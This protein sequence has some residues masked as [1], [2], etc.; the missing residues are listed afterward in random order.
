MLTI[1]PGAI[2][3]VNIIVPKSFGDQRG[4]FCEVYNRKRFFEHGIT[5]E[6][7]QD[8][9][10]WSALK[11]TVRGLH[12]Q[13]APMAQ[14]KLVW[15]PHGRIFDV[16][17]DLRRSSPSYGRWVTEEL[18]AENGRQLLI[19]VGFAHGFCTLEPD[20]HVFYK[21]T[22]Y[23]SPEADFGIAWDD[24]DLA[25]DW[26]IRREDALLSEKDRKLPPFKSLPSYFE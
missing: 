14:A 5:L 21:V 26:P 20:T 18:S 6:F 25:I 22:N 7:V 15:V 2:P 1:T 9:Q 10:S 19:P 16:A 24:L 13:G 11:G 3:A 4:N 23:Y 8:N 17:I 12:F